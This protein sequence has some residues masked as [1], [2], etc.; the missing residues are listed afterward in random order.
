MFRSIQNH[1]V[2][3]LAVGAVAFGAWL[4]CDAT[5][6]A[7][8]PVGAVDAGPLPQQVHTMPVPPHDPRPMLAH[9]P[10]GAPRALV[11]HQLGVFPMPHGVSA[12]NLEDGSATY[13]VT[14]PL[15]SGPLVLE[16]DA[17]RPGHPFVGPRGEPQS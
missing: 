4:W 17:A 5:P 2:A 16:F 15:P 1:P 10:P 13:T 11:E 9:L 3:L 14:Y 7:A 8:A 6:S 12:I